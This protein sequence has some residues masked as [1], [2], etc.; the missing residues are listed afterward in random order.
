MVFSDLHTS[1]A[2]NDERTINLGELR[3]ERRGSLFTVKSNPTADSTLIDD[4]SVRNVELIRD[5][6]GI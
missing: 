5:V 3:P 1:A 6:K 2:R 4:V